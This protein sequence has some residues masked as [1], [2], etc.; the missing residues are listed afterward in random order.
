VEH[1]IPATTEQLE[2]F[3]A[4]ITEYFEFMEEERETDPDGLPPGIEQSI[5]LLKA[6]RSKC[7]TALSSSR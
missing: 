7:L 3:V 6:L 2:A 4:T 1:T 5:P